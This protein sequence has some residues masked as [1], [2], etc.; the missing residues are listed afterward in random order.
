GLSKVAEGELCVI[1]DDDGSFTLSGRCEIKIAGQKV[2][3]LEATVTARVDWGQQMWHLEKYRFGVCGTNT[4][5]LKC[6]TWEGT[7]LQGK[8]KDEAPRVF[9]LK[10]GVAANDAD[11]MRA[12]LSIF[13][14]RQGEVHPST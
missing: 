5:E 2:A 11:R 7:G 3:S 9:L 6:K 4:F 14:P 12:L 1:K 8:G 13:E 10:N